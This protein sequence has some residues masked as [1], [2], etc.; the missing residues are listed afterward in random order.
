MSAWATYV[1]VVVSI[2]STFWVY[3][4]MPLWQKLL[5]LALIVL[6]TALMI[7]GAGFCERL[8]NMWWQAAY[9]VGV[10]TLGSLIFYLS[11]GAAWLVLLPVAAQTTYFFPWSGTL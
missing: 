8:G 10:S 3:P 1:A 11:G 7:A 4:E 2:V 9:F 5:F 6:H